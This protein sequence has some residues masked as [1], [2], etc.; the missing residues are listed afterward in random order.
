MIENS[1]L[2]GARAVTILASGRE[3]LSHVIGIGSAKEFCIMAGEA[4]GGECGELATAMAIQTIGCSVCSTQWPIIVTEAADAAPS[5]G[6]VAILAVAHPALRE[7]IGGGNICREIAMACFTGSIGRVKQTHF[8][9][10]VAAET[11]CRS[12]RTD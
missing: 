1:A 8:G 4:S 7:V 3:A 6:H 12:M 2:P 9:A 11:G 10:G 5:G